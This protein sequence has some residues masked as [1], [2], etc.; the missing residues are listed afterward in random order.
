MLSLAKISRGLGLSRD[1]LAAARVGRLLTDSFLA[2]RPDEKSFTA[3]HA[4]KAPCAVPS[5]HAE[6]PTVRTG[7]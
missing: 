4:I 2:P 1:G 7:P 6:R 3:E 5:R